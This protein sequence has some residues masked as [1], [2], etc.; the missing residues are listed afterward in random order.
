MLQDHK[1]FL[2]TS[3]S[4]CQGWYNEASQTLVSADLTPLG[5]LRALP[6]FRFTFCLG[7]WWASVAPSPSDT[8][9]FLLKENSGEGAVMEPWCAVALACS[10]PQSPLASQTEAPRWS[11]IFWWPSA[12]YC[13][14]QKLSVW[15]ESETCSLHHPRTYQHRERCSMANWL[16]ALSKQQFPQKP[17]SED[18]I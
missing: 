5:I 15:Y 6:S 16:Y 13:T 14:L 4:L 8:S 1:W 18:M 12:F 2:P 3:T 9:C 10:P 11:T 7:C 17:T